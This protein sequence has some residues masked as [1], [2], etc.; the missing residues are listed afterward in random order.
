MSDK[1]AIE[2]ALRSFAIDLLDLTE[3]LGVG[4][5]TVYVDG[6][7]NSKY[8]QFAAW[9]VDGVTPVVHADIFTDEREGES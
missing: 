7:G 9:G 5:A 4:P 2:F 1:T 8:M 3:R 6:R